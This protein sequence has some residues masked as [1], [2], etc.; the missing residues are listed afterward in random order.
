MIVCFLHG[1]L[2]VVFFAR[3]LDCEQ[4]S[5]WRSES[6]SCLVKL[7]SI[8]FVRLGSVSFLRVKKILSKGVFS[9]DVGAGSC[10]V[11]AFCQLFAIDSKQIPTLALCNQNPTLFFIRIVPQ[12]LCFEK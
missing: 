6:E 2:I 12:F 1:S 11:I 3:R 10:F 5:E 9:E 4:M 7:E 8:C